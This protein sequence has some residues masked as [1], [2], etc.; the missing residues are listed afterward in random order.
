[1]S[2][3]S[4]VLALA[5]VAVVGAVAWWQRDAILAALFGPS[6]VGTPGTGVVIPRG[7]SGAEPGTTYWIDDTLIRVHVPTDPAGYSSRDAL[8]A[9][10][11]RRNAW[12]RNFCEAAGMI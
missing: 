10:Y 4:D 3:T 11:C 12:D 2:I 1:M 6:Y 7:Q 9:D 8:V 5:G